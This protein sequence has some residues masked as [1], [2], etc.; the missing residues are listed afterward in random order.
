V[1]KHF[2]AIAETC[3][4]FVNGVIDDLVDKMMESEF[5]G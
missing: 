3:E 4:G 2:Y 1:N 5:T